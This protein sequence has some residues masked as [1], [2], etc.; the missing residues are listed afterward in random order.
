MEMTKTVAIHS[1][2]LF[3]RPALKHFLEGGC[4]KTAVASF[5]QEKVNR[6]TKRPVAGMTATLQRG[7]AQLTIP[8]A[9]LS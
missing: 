5:R 4:P 6:K 8:A 3:F 2:R 7:L 1:F 9:F